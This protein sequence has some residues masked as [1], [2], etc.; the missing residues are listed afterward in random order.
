MN[1]RESGVG[2]IEKSRGFSVLELLAVLMIFGVVAGIALP[3][4]TGLIHSFRRDAA[5]QQIAGDVRRARTEAIRTGW[6]YRIFGF[7][8]GSTSANKNQYRFQARSSGAVAW[9]A[10]TVAPFTSTTQMAGQWV[11][12]TTQFPGVSLNPD[13]TTERFWVSFDPRGVRIELDDSFDPL[14]ITNT[15]GSTKS[16]AVAT[17]GSVKVQ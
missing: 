14:Y 13:D 4:F 10:D 2:L 8:S 3:K 5:I 7:N 1:N 15:T 9:P 11:N 6:Q 17:V 12:F 16:V